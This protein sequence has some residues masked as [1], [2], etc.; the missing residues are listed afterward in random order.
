MSFD[1]SSRSSKA[2][3]NRYAGL[4]E[5][6]ELTESLSPTPARPE[7]PGA[8]EA[9]RRPKRTIA[10]LAA[11]GRAKLEA[12]RQK[13]ENAALPTV[14]QRPA[15]VPQT[16]VD[17]LEPNVM[18]GEETALEEPPEQ[19]RLDLKRYIHY[20]NPAELF[21][22]KPNKALPCMIST[23]NCGPIGSLSEG[24]PGHR[25]ALYLDQG[26]KE[27]A[28]MRLVFK[29]NKDP[30]QNGPMS[31]YEDQI[32]SFNIK[33]SLGKLSKCPS[34]FLIQDMAF[35]L[36]SDTPDSQLEPADRTVLQQPK[37][38]PTKIMKLTLSVKKHV[39]TGDDP[40]LWCN[41]HGEAVTANIHNFLH[42]RYSVNVY[43]LTIHGL[44]PA[45]ENLH[46][47]LLERHQ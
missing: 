43:C 21:L 23:Q 46:R 33:L 37:F 12:K 27:L 47:T 17:A 4:E 29:T 16:P 20:P 44:R 45:L 26:T 11:A 41:R 42:G 30:S 38:G 19:N 32:I 34:D 39:L 10:E 15:S 2:D 22:R 36:L 8:P 6:S 18:G 7:A 24:N 35:H 3:Q 31:R 1:N 25:I 5:V 28:S 40:L 13:E 9:P 14:Q